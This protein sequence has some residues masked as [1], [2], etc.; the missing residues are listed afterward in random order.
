M[1]ILNSVCLLR[2]PR[3]RQLQVG[4]AELLCMV[5]HRFA[6]KMVTAAVDSRSLYPPATHTVLLG[7]FYL[8]GC[9]K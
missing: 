4:K 5:F 6:C 8:L 9:E 7:L 3:P 1:Y 2:E